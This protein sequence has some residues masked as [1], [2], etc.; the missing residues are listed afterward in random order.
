LEL[1]LEN[2]KPTREQLEQNERVVLQMAQALMIE[3]DY[4]I[5]V[6]FLQQ[7]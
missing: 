6:E 1:V 7:D 2:H 4:N 5:V 3:R